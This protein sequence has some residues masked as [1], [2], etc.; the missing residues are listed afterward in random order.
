MKL[1]FWIAGHLLAMLLAVPMLLNAQRTV[2]EEVP[3]TFSDTTWYD[4]GFDFF[5]GGGMYMGNS[6]NAKYYSGSN[7]NECNL[8]YIF[9]NENWRREMMEAVVELYPYVSQSDVLSYDELD[10][11]EMD[12]RYKV[13]TFLNLGVRTKLRDGWGISLSYSFCRLSSSHKVLLEY[14]NVPSLEKKPELT[15]Y[16]KEDRSLIDLSMSYLFSK[17]HKVVKPFVEVGAQFT[18]AKA[19]QFD[20]ILLNKDNVEMRS[21][22]MLDPYNGQSYTPGMI[23]YDAIYGGPGFGF[24]AAAGIK[25]AFNNIVSIDPTFYCSMSKFGIFPGKNKGGSNEFG[26]NYGAVVRIVMTDF[27]VNRNN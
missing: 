20:A 9:S 22:T 8:D 5:I 6:Y 17:V 27:F 19:K 26:F 16:A 25:F 11:L 1:K 2:I 21:W 24:S 23:E 7:Q 13:K 10:I 18:Y 14:S 3:V 12:V 4:K 15:L